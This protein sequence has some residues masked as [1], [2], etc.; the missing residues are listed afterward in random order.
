MKEK[1]Q[2]FWEIPKN[3]FLTFIFAALLFFLFWDSLAEEPAAGPMSSE[4]TAKKGQEFKA[5]E[6]PYSDKRHI[7]IQA[8]Q[9]PVLKDPFLIPA[10][11]QTQQKKAETKV[12]F[13]DSSMQPFIA[14]S[15]AVQPAVKNTVQPPVAKGIVHSTGQTVA[16]LEYSGQSGEYAKGENVGPY[17]VV[18]I[19]TEWIT[20][21]GPEGRLSLKV[22][23]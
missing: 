22:G 12:S 15:N 16:I 10:E 7:A 3:R 20:L 2:E 6:K 1:L 9:K 19:Y 23:R 4:L 14:K 5:E 8:N 13:S 11:Y 21:E 17:K 18:S